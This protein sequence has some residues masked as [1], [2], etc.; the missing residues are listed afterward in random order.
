MKRSR[1][2]DVLQKFFPGTSRSRRRRAVTGFPQT[3]TVQLETRCLLSADVAVQLIAGS[4]YVTGAAAGDRTLD[5]AP[6]DLDPTVLNFTPGPNTTVNGSF[7]T[8]QIPLSKITKNVIINLNNGVTGNN[9]TVLTFD[10]GTLSVAGALS[11]SMAGK[12]ADTLIFNNGQFKGAATVFLGTGDDMASL[13]GLKVGG[14]TLIDSGLGTDSVGLHS[15]ILGAVSI[16]ERGKANDVRVDDSVLSS[17][18][19][20]EQGSQT[21]TSLYELSV[22]GSLTVTLAAG[23][24][25]LDI[26]E[27]TVGGA[28]TVA[29][30]STPGASSFGFDRLEAKSLTVSCGNGGYAI[31]ANQLNIQN[32]VTITA[33]NGNTDIGLFE[34]IKIGGLTYLSVGKGNSAIGIVGSPSPTVTAPIATLHAININVGSGQT[35]VILNNLTATS[36]NVSAGTGSNF[37][38]LGGDITVPELPGDLYAFSGTTFLGGSATFTGPVSI[39]SLGTGNQAFIHESFFKSSFTLVD[40]GSQN[41]LFVSTSQFNGPTNIVMY[42]TRNFVGIEVEEVMTTSSVL[43]ELPS[44]SFARGLNV[45]FPQATAVGNGGLVRLGTNW[46]PTV[47]LGQKST[48]YGASVVLSDALVGASNIKL[49]FSKFIDLPI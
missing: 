34:T 41:S 23:R 2:I 40:G 6:D 14:G 16:T 36:L 1:L 28:V 20:L 11:V 37:F 39:T 22:S 4:L 3:G 8:L 7:D 9:A 24:Q 15:S 43:F 49:I 19:I 45:T 48:I 32:N 46:G 27:S 10:G 38:A 12:G 33:G 17:L 35:G 26:N 47:V 42:G 29:A 5:V 25:G 30:G 31:Q 13:T 18:S 44:T 21:V